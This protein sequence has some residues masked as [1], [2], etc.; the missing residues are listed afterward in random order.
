MFINACL[1]CPWN[2]SLTLYT[3]EEGPVSPSS[4]NVYGSS[5]SLV[6]T[7]VLACQWGNKMRN[8]LLWSKNLSI[9]ELNVPFWKL[10]IRIKCDY[11]T[12]CSRSCSTNTSVIYWSDIEN[13]RNLTQQDCL[14]PDFTPECANYVNFEIATKQ[15]NLG[16]NTMFT[17]FTG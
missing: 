14:F 13:V 5:W 8:N 3:I 12:R 10:V 1:F 15:H 6:W 17:T 2:E 11:M 16:A 7:T 9:I 4:S